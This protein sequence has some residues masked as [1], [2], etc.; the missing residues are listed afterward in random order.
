MY[1]THQLS[2]LAALRVRI[3]PVLCLLFSV[4]CFSGCS[5]TPRLT[6]AEHHARV[7]RARNSTPYLTHIGPTHSMSTIIRAGGQ[8]TVRPHP[9]FAL[10]SGM[11]VVYWPYGHANPIC[12]FLAGRIGTDSWV[13]RGS[14]NQADDLTLL[15]TL[16][17]RE[18]YIG[19]IW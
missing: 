12:H 11:I 6:P 9:Y 13:A 15:G 5:T 3:W 19:V 1:F 10:Q 2:A 14:W 7:A 17:T 16:V 18:N 4:L 8:A